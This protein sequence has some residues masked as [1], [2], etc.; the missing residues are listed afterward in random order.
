MLWA[1]ELAHVMQYADWGVD[2]FVER[3]L[4]DAS[5]VEHAANDLAWEW[6]Q[7][8]TGGAPAP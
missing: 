8:S 1:H 5:A 6:L 7:A 2:G 3:Y 4:A